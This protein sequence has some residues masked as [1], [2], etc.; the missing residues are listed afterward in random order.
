MDFDRSPADISNDAAEAI[1]QLNHRTRTE[2]DDW[3]Y[4]GDAYST[5]A[6]LAYLAG[7]LPQA[8]A[9][10]R[11]LMQRLESSGN[12]RSDKDTVGT[13]LS[14]TFAG[15]DDAR[16]AAEQLYAALNRAHAGLGSLAYEV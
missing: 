8:L 7:G 10:I 2:H 12:L 16:A 6:N 5:V 3:Q 11:A 9:Q 14:E 1:R 4:P 15:L 13:D